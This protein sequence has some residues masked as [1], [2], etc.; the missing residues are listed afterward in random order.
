MPLTELIARLLAHNN[1]QASTGTSAANAAAAQ[2]D[3]T[4]AP[5]AGVG[6]TTAPA[7][8][9]TAAE[10]DPQTTGAQSSSLE[11]APPAPASDL[12]TEL[13]KRKSR[14][15]RFGTQTSE[16]AEA[17]DKKAERL[18]RFGQDADSTAEQASLDK[19][20]SALSGK[21]ERKFGGKRKLPEGMEA[22]PT[23][24]KKA[25]P[26]KTTA[27]TTDPVEEEKKRKRMEEDAEK[28]RQ[29]LEKFGDAKVRLLNSNFAFSLS[30]SQ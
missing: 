28:K 17:T 30:V 20:D 15:A 16:G 10:A 2:A 7:Q 24:P 5:Q 25:A 18:Q 29:R 26:E 19:L 14:A 22:V 23:S 21:R 4:A 9:A 3:G 12:N 6:S 11:T 1:G 13:D 8:P 27:K